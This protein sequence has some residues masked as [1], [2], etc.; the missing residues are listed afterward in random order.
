MRNFSFKD[1]GKKKTVVYNQKSI[2]DLH[3]L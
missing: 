3:Y 1:K 2:R